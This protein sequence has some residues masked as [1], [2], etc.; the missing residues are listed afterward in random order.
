M[1][2]FLVANNKKL[3]KKFLDSISIDLENDTVVFFN[4][5][6]PFFLFSRLNNCKNKIYI[7]RQLGS[8]IE[9]HSK[10]MQNIFPY[11]GMIEI[12]KM[13]EHF[14]KIIFY[15]CPE[16]LQE[17]K[18]TMYRN[19]IN[20]FRYEDNK[21]DC[22]DIN[23][24]LI[25]K[26]IKYPQSKSVSTGLIMYEYLKLDKKNKINLIGFTSNLSKKYHDKDFEKKY[27]DNEFKNKKCNIINEK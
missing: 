5:M 18:K 13:E 16:N 23:V 3:T 10:G 1:N 9:K 19:F 14:Q 12:K 7:S 24:P 4:Y 21:I 26:N 2:Y 15:N 6:Q 22:L 11:A 20:T 17:P 27:F 8:F 25:K